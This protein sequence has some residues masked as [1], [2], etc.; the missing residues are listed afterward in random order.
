MHHKYVGNTGEDV[1]LKMTVK[2][3]YSALQNLTSIE[4]ACVHM[5][6]GY[7]FPWWVVCTAGA[8]PIGCNQ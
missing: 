5:W 7:N 1:S 2:M 6:V 8:K 4:L 3:L